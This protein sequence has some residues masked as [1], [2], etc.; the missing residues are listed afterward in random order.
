MAPGLVGGPKFKEVLVVGFMG[1][2]VSWALLASFHYPGRVAAIVPI[3]GCWN[4]GRVYAP[5]LASYPM[6]NCLVLAPVGAGTICDGDDKLLVEIGA[7][8][9]I[10]LEDKP[11]SE[12]VP[13]PEFSVVC[14]SGSNAFHGKDFGKN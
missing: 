9:M 5:P 11:Q 14:L 7:R 13:D 12:K 10:K 6:T 4:I 8:S 1:A 3:N 2:D